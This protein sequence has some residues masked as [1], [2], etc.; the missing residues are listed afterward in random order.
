MD[1]KIRS[2][3]EDVAA[4]W[5]S[6]NVEKIASFFTEDCLFEDVCCGNSYRGQEAFKAQAKAVIA[7]VPDLQ[8]KIESVFSEGDWMGGEWIET[9][10]QDG[11]RFSV[12]GASI[13]VLEKG[14]IKRESMY[15]HFDGAIWFD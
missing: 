8:L 2:L 13:L 12:R 4:A 6:H 11:K 14:K 10:T 3:A 5:S 1:N 15:C 9:G 7:A